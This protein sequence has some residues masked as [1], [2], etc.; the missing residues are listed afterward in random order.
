LSFPKPSDA[1]WK[2][3]VH[4]L[5]LLGAMAGGETFQIGP[6]QT[7][8]HFVPGL[9][10]PFIALLHILFMVVTIYVKP[11]TFIEIAQQRWAIEIYRQLLF[12]NMIHFGGRCEFAVRAISGG[13]EVSV[14]VEA[15]RERKTVVRRGSVLMGL[16]PFSFKRASQILKT[17]RND[18]Q[19]VDIKG[20]ATAGAATSWKS[21]DS[22]NRGSAVRVPSEGA[23]MSGPPEL[24]EGCEEE[25][26]RGATA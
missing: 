5:D 23:A 11:E 21:I 10:V 7:E 18:R 15:G 8:I 19:E 14:N 13:K 2:E 12:R 16:D 6:Q 25:K 9:L 17:G 4:K 26:N 1:E 3:I 20:H 22:A 24:R